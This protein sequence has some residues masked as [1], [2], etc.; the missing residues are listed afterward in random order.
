MSEGFSTNAALGA[1]ASPHLERFLT[2]HNLSLVLTSRQAN[3]VLSLGTDPASGRLWLSHTGFDRPSGIE[4][5]DDKMLLVT[6][7]RL[8]TFAGTPAAGGVVMSPRVAYFTGALDA[9]DAGFGAHG[10]IYFINTR[11]SCVACTSSTHSFRPLWVPPFITK[12]RAEDRCHLNGLAL[13]DGHPAFATAL[14]QTD[15]ADSWRDR[16]IGGGVVMDI[17]RDEVLSHNLVMPHSPRMHQGSLWLL[18]GGTGRLGA[19]T[20]QGFEPLVTCPGFVRGLA[21]FGQYA[22]V[23]LSHFRDED[24]TFGGL[25]VADQLARQG[26]KARCAIYIIDLNDGSVAHWLRFTGGVEEIF[27]IAAVPQASR[28][29]IVSPAMADWQNAIS[30]E[31]GQA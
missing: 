12:L 8:L 9:H 24:P 4:I 16:R 1:Q 22:V 31:G 2:E 17:T 13:R 29:H 21:F 6:H 19:V 7:D 3:A 23:G 10:G 18:E 26:L 20:D 25:P 27:D 14:S 11:Y 15:G 30:I 28:V 5:C